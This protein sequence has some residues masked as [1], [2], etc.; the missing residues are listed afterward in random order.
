MGILAAVA[1]PRLSGFGKSNA[2]ISATRQLLDD[3]ALAR[4]MAVSRRSDVY[5]VFIPPV[6]W[7]TNESPSAY[8]DLTRLGAVDNAATNRFLGGQFTTYALYSERTV[9]DQPGRDSP[10]YLTPW[11]TLPQG[12]FI[13]TNKFD[14]NTNFVM[15]GVH[16]FEWRSVPFP[17]ATNGQTAW[18]PCIVFTSRGQLAS[19]RD[20]GGET[21]P[22]ARGSIF[23][24]RN[25]DGS[26]ASPFTPDVSENPPG[27][28]R[29]NST[30][31]N[32]VHI[33]A[34]TGRARVERQEVQ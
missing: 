26:I 13:A 22:L 30:M 28:S 25:P 23:Y 12:T 6:P 5:M 7:T 17:Q 33:D 15:D 11:K 9:G 4:S 19:T 16:A 8:Y 20:D 18:L 1:L 14:R 2:T 32:W 24:P 27:N 3:I 29:T 21:I 31:W 10:R 34:L